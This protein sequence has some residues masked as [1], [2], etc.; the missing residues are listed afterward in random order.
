MIEPTL[1]TKVILLPT[2]K[3]LPSFSYNPYNFGYP[4]PTA[5]TPYLTAS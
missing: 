3:L 4:P 5:Y 2:L 1:L